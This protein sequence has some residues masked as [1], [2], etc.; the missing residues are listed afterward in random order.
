MKFFMI[1]LLHTERILLDVLTQLR[2]AYFI[3]VTPTV[4]HHIGFCILPLEV[5]VA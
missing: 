5:L 2:E 4:L 3:Q 1:F